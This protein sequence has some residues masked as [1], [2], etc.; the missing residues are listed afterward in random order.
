PSVRH[1]RGPDAP[2]GKEAGGFAHR[3]LRRAAYDMLV[4]SSDHAGARHGDS[5]FAPPASMARSGKGAKF[6]R[7]G[8]KALQGGATVAI[9]G[10]CRCDRL[11]TTPI[12]PFT[13]GRATSG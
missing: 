2:F 12:R 11:W 5:P 8:R 4:V 7:G 1:R 9:S 10:A 3:V 13:L 6:A